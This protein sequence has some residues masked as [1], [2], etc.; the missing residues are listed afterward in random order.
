M[1]TLKWA[2]SDP[3]IA[4][5]D[6]NGVVTGVSEGT[7]EITITSNN[8]KSAT[9]KLTVKDIPL[10]DIA[11]F[12]SLAVG[13]EE[14]LQFKQA[15]VLL[16]NGETAFVRDASGALMLLGFENL[17]TNDVIDGT[18]FV[19]VG[20]KDE[21]SQA[22][23][24]ENTIVSGLTIAAGNQVKPREVKLEDLTKNDYC[25]YVLVKAA[26]MVTKKVDGKSGV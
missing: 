10:Y 23:V 22:L 7:C 14:L 25:D 26:K 20:E 12:K 19:Q 2:S 15:E 9:C 24:T 11:G 6:N 3:T 8:G 5:V 16:A 18:L 17:K 21:L 4:T 13:S 1:A